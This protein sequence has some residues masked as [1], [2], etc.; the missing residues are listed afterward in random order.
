MT[1]RSKFT[2]AR[3]ASAHAKGFTLIEL[4]VVIAIIALLISLLLPALSKA[5]TLAW[6][7]KS[8]SNTHQLNVSSVSY[9]SDNKS[10]PPAVMSWTRTWYPPN[11]ANPA[12]GYEGFATWAFIGKNNDGY[13]AG[14]SFDV[15][16]ADRPLNQYFAPQPFDGPDRPAIMG[17]ND[18]RRKA[19]QL[20]A[21][22]DPSD[23]VS[24]QRNW[25]PSNP[26]PTYG[27]SCY[28]DVGSSYHYQVKWYDPIYAAWTLNSLGGRSYASFNFGTKRLSVSSGFVPARMVWVNDQYADIVANCTVTSFRLKN[29]YGDINKS[30]MGFMDGHATYVNVIPGNLPIS[31]QNSEY[32]FVFDSLAVPH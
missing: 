25:N 10:Y 20:E 22:R 30:V 13:W 23:R 19:Q 8:L 27:L 29:G 1:Q 3:N 21:V 2:T 18:S 26:T 12:T 16:A 31:F 5:R 6:L 14:Q 17:V 4:L 7:A 9:G 11:P 32:S 15:E 28:D 24:F